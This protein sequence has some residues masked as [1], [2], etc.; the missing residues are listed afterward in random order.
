MDSEIGNQAGAQNTYNRRLDK[1]VSSADR[2]H[3]L[4]IAAVYDLP[5]GRGKAFGNRMP[6][7]LDAFIGSWRISAI[8]RYSERRAPGHRFEPESVRRG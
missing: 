3:I 7:I 8:Q 4:S 5:V 1:A 6:K 2:P